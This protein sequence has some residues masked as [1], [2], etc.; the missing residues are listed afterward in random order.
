MPIE[1]FKVSEHYREEAG[2]RYVAHRQSDPLHIGHQLNFEYFRAYLKSTDVLL[3][4]G[5]GNGGL[6]RIVAKHVRRADGLE[7]NPH[8]AAMAR[9]SGLEVFG[10]LG[11]LP[12]KPTYDAVLSNHVL[13]HIRDVPGTLERLREA[14]KPG[15]RLLLKL[16]INDWRA[17]HERGWSKDDIDHHLQT[18]TPRLIGNVLYEAGFE[19]DDIKVIASAWHP[20]LFPLVKLGVGRLG[21]WALAVLLKRRQLFVI[22]HVPID[23]ES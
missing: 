13:E 6:L 14:M 16:P 23:A 11:D 7:V 5:C 22:G 15:A 4:F 21:F 8:A 10:S 12:R 19:V 17:R 18:W 2:Q 20:R 3:D 9:S 1:D